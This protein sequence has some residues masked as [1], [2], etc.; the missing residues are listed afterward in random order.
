MDQGGQGTCVAYSMFSQNMRP[1]RQDHGR[2]V[3]EPTRMADGIPVSRSSRPGSMRMARRS[4]ARLLVASARRTLRYR[5]LFRSGGMQGFAVRTRGLACGFGVDLRGVTRAR[6]K[7]RL[8]TIRDKLMPG[9]E[10]M[11][12][13]PCFL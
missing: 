13:F 12:R 6:P 9:N 2:A 5:L 8:Q 4:G 10:T 1:L 11:K 7:K 3:D